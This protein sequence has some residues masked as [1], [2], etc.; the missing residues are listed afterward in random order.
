MKQVRTRPIFSDRKRPHV[1]STRR[2]RMNVGKAIRCGAW[3]ADTVAGPRA[4]VS[5]TNLRVG[6]DKAEKLSFS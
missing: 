5:I 4:N 6:S 2:W 3:R 1:S